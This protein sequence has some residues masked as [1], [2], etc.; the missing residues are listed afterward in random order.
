MAGIGFELRKLA[1]RGSAKGL[2]QASLS[3]IMIV[4]GPWIISIMTILL[5]QQPFMG[6]PVSFRRLFISSTIYIYSSS[7]VLTGG[8][9]YIFTRILSDFI[10]R[11][12]LDKAM[13]L[14]SRYV[15]IST[16][17]LVPLAVLLQGIFLKNVPVLHR[18]SFVFLFVLI[19][20]IWILMLTA[21]AMKR[22]NQLLFVYL[23][24][25]ASS[26]VF[27][28]AAVLY[29]DT[30]YLLMAYTAGQ[31][32]VFLLLFF[33]LYREM[34]TGKVSL[35]SLFFPYLI[36]Y[37]SLFITGFVYYGALWIDKMV[38]WYLRG[39]FIDGTIMK[40]YQS[41]DVIVYY[42]NLM[43]I[44]GLVFFVIFSETEFYIVLKKFLD[45]LGKK[46][47]KT[48]KWNTY[49]L[50]RT[51]RF[52][53]IEQFALQGAVVL[54]FLRLTWEHPVMRQSFSM[55]FVTAAGIVILDLFLTVM[56]FLFYIERYGAALLGVSVFF[57]INMTG[58]MLS[59]YIR[60]FSLPGVSSL[61][62]CFTGTVILMIFLYRDLHSLDRI[63]FSSMIEK[64]LKEIPSKNMHAGLGKKAL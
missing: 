57:L 4:A 35:G 6:I 13:G 19:N 7:L 58:A 21:S 30:S 28:K 9:H 44:P 5:F 53:L 47:Y 22:F 16:L 55:V 14:T 51:S 34:G 27:L 18:W 15:G 41:Y 48:I 3:G 43:M 20:H 2:F 37:K 29:L 61:T 63:I 64:Q 52:I 60:F 39:D 11:N 36:R 49:R 38:F 59:P 17:F 33:Y 32:I 1:T 56:N 10:Y 25:M 62:G 42:S 8:F 45:S 26:L 46:P 23:L 31:L 54:L 50:I 40:L 12:E 24:G